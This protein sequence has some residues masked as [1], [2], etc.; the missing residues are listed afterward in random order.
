[1]KSSPPSPSPDISSLHDRT[2]RITP[3]ACRAITP[4]SLHDC[5]CRSYRHWR[6]CRGV[7][8]AQ[9]SDG[10]TT[11]GALRDANVGR[12][13]DVRG[14]AAS[15][16]P[17]RRHVGRTLSTP[18]GLMGGESSPRVTA[19]RTTAA[20]ERAGLAVAAELAITCRGDHAPGDLARTRRRGRGREDGGARSAA[21][22][23]RRVA[24]TWA[25]AAG[26]A[27]GAELQA[28]PGRPG[29]RG[30]RP[31]PTSR[32][33]A[34]PPARGSRRRTASAQSGLRGRRRDRRATGRDRPGSPR[35][36]IAVVDWRVRIVERTWGCRERIR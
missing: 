30:F 27:A 5:D 24:P 25:R 35:R 34:R 11:A 22:A 31:A 20:P 1:M 21:L 26:G 32:P 10:T 36:H 33:A 2:G 19:S 12:Y 29:A 6:D 13:V 16:Q 15:P 28:A 23:H 18:P 14:Q 4:S 8:S 17:R 3:A 9:P 7:H